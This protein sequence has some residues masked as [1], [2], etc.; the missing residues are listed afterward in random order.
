MMNIDGGG[1][2]MTGEE[3][4]AFIKVKGYEEK[5]YN[6][7]NMQDLRIVLNLVEKQDKI[8]NEMAEWIAQGGRLGFTSEEIIEYFK[9]KIT[10]NEK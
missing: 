10:D 1:R 5:E 8:I 7:L 6:S 2:A 4:V 3:K 9:E